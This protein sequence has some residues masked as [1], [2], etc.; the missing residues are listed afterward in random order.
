MD[1]TVHPVVQ[2]IPPQMMLD[3]INAYGIVHSMVQITP[4]NFFNQHIYV[5][6]D[7]GHLYGIAL[8]CLAI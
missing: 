5:H 3:R 4:A 6:V 2:N 7:N 8:M 1:A